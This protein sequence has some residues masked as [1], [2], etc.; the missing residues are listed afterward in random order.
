MGAVSSLKGIE[1]GIIPGREQL[2]ATIRAAR[3]RLTRYR[4][5]YTVSYTDRFGKERVL[6]QA[7]PKQDELH[8]CK[9]RNILYG[10][11]AGGSKSHGLRWDAIIKALRVPGFRAL[12][13]RRTFTEL[14]QTHLLALQTEFPP[15]LGR[16]VSSSKRLIIKHSD[17]PDSI[18][19]F[20]HCQYAKDVSKYLSTEW[21][22][23]YLDEA[24]TF[25]PIQVTQLRSRLRSTNP[26][27]RPQLICASN[28]GGDL[29][30]WLDDLFISKTPSKD[31][32]P[33]YRPED[34]EFI[35]ARVTDN[36]Y[37]SDD[38]IDRLLELP[39]LLQRAYLMGDWGVFAG[40]FWREWARSLHVR[41]MPRALLEDGGFPAWMEREGAMDWGYSPDPFVVLV[42]AFDSIGRAWL[43]R[44]ISGTNCSPREVAEM[45]DGACPEGRVRGFLIRGDTQMWQKNPE[46][47]VSI[48]GAI[49]DRLAELGSLITLV[50]ANK[51]RINGWMAVRTWL[52]P[53]KREPETG[54]I[55]PA[56]VVIDPDR[57]DG[58]G[59][60]GLIASM[61]PQKF[62][63][64]KAGD[65]APNPRDHWCDALRYLLVAR[66]PISRHPD[67][68]EL[69]LPHHQRV[70]AKRAKV[71]KRALE[72]ARAAE[73]AQ[74]SGLLDMGA[75]EA[76]GFEPD[77]PQRVNPWHDADADVA[78]AFR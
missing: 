46:S 48:A 65:M 49:N 71:M 8:G 66:G 29:H 77:D 60:P 59:C 53:R 55:V 76:A 39:E 74:A 68:G 54:E 31:D 35:R 38:Y 15:E 2:R 52:E 32:A 27:I 78:D 43:Y 50:G 20:G 14:E 25:L 16:Y 13:L 56:L 44:E 58:Y 10:G 19:Q 45:I 26:K 22:A 18:V 4:S 1:R 36:A 11:A 23:I 67:D 7:Q 62:H 40:Q 17:G 5:R 70:H 51:D 41:P 37:I 9:A 30:G 64:L 12:F 34:Y 21:D 73:E 33:N 75:L 42:A 6:Y 3:D 69:G 63:E 47:G 24:S 61:P 57:G 72:L 28:P